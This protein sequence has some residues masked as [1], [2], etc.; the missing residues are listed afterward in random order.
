MLKS[1]PCFCPFV[2]DTVPGGAYRLEVKKDDGMMTVRAEYADKRDCFSYRREKDEHL[3]F[4]V[5]ET[6]RVMRLLM[7]THD[8]FRFYLGAFGVFCDRDDDCFLHGGT[9]EQALSVDADV[10][11][12]IPRDQM[13]IAQT[14]LLKSAPKFHPDGALKA[15]NILMQNCRSVRCKPETDTARMNTLSLYV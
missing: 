13:L 7:I 12:V 8:T 6:G 5:F 1:F 9:K 14:F 15:E 10:P 4:D 3:V 11:V 2:E